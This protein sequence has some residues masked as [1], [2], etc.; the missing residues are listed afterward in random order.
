MFVYLLAFPPKTLKSK[1]APHI[2]SFLSSS[3]NPLLLHRVCVF[4]LFLNLCLLSSSAFYFTHP[5]FPSASGSNYIFTQSVRWLTIIYT[6]Y[7]FIARLLCHTC[8]RQNGLWLVYCFFTLV[9][10]LI[11]LQWIHVLL[12]YLCPSFAAVGVLFSVEVMSSHFALKHYLPCFF[13]AA[14]GALTFRLLAVW[15]GDG[16]NWSTH[17]PLMVNKEKVHFR[18]NDTWP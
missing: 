11:C 17:R 10:S 16:G 1:Q 2:S 4:R 5:S 7:Y 3:L 14:C 13:S 6:W 9:S 12:L 18:V 15:S 8:R